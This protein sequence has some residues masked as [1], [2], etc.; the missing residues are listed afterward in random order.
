MNT[1]RVVAVVLVAGSM[2]IMQMQPCIAQCCLTDFFAGL[3]SC[4]QTAPPRP[5][6]VAP[7]MAQPIPVV[8][9][10]V[11]P[12]PPPQPVMVPVQ[13]VSYVPET[14]YKTQYECVP[15]TCYRPVTE[16]DPC[17]GCA[18]QCMQQE[19]TYVQ[20][21]VNV[22]YTQYRAVYSTKMVAVQPGA[23]GTAI[24]PSATY[25]PAVT[26]PPAAAAVS[27]FAAPVQQPAGWAAA[28]SDVPPTL[29]PQQGTVTQPIAPQQS[30][31]QQIIPQSGTLSPG[32]TYAQPIPSQSGATLQQPMLSPTAP[33]QLSPA[34]GPQTSTSPSQSL[35]P[36][37]EPAPSSAS[38]P[39]QGGSTTQQ[40][41]Q[42]LQPAPS[43]RPTTLQPSPAPS[44]TQGLMPVVPGNGPN[45]ATGAFPRLLEPTG[46]TTR[47]PA[48]ASYPTAALPSRLQ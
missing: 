42:G 23:A 19:T 41:T 28:G 18:T 9:P 47:S 34:P 16:V 5:V 15:V 25:A 33:P 3:G 1:R 31:Q 37:P 32:Q 2:A 7:V 29:V 10:V 30:F 44:N 39:S 12:A 22:P 35:R 36:I 38:A 21:A 43:Q 27:P 6:A 45:T 13:Q 48:A 17:T 11:A 40:P 24:A 4:C 20:K 14:C 26:T 8:A 46:H